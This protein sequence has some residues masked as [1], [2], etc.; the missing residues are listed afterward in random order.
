MIPADNKG[1]TMTKSLFQGELVILLALRNAKA[2]VLIRPKCS[3]KNKSGCLFN[4]ILPKKLCRVLDSDKFLNHDRERSSLLLHLY[5]WQ[6]SI[7]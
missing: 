6:Q 1:N 3:K 4:I 7:Q 5:A 2:K